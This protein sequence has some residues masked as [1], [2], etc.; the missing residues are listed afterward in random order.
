MVV[1]S[2]KLKDKSI[3]DSPTLKNLKKNK[4]IGIELL[5]NQNIKSLAFNA[6]VYKTRDNFSKLDF[7]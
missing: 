2:E 6:C 5:R 3:S 4:E 1:P 7:P